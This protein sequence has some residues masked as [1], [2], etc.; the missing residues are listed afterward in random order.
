MPWQLIYTS[1]P[2]T[3][4]AGQTG[5]G[6]VARSKDLRDALIQRLE[7][8]S[9]FQHGDSHAATPPI[10]HAYRIVD[11]RGAKYHVLT[12]LVDAGLDFTNRTNHLAHHLVFTAEELAALPS[13]SLIFQHWTGWR[14]SWTEEPRALEAGDGPAFDE[15]PCGASLPA[16]EWAKLT[17]DAGR[18]AALVTR[19]AANGCWLAS[20]PGGEMTWLALFAESLQ[21]LDPEK[22]LPAQRWQFP[23]TTRLQEQDQPNDFRWR[24][25]EPGSPAAQRA[26]AQIFSP[27]DLPVPSG[28]LAEL[29]RRGPK[30][31]YSVPS[32]PRV[33]TV[34]TIH[35]KPPVKADVSTARPLRLR[36]RDANAPGQTARFD[37]DSPDEPRRSSS[38]RRVVPIAAAILL[39]ALLVTGFWRPGWMMKRVTKASGPPE[40]KTVETVGTEG[41]IISDDFS[42]VPPMQG[43][44]LIPPHSAPLPPSSATLDQLSQI[45]DGIPTYL[46]DANPSEGASLPRIAELESLLTS[47][48]KQS[49]P[50]ATDAIKVFASSDRLVFSG[51][52]EAQLSVTRSEFPRKILMGGEAGLKFELDATEWFR[53]P[54]G[55]PSA[56]FNGK[57]L[58]AASTVFRPADGTTFPPVRIL[59]L[60]EVAPIDLGKSLLQINQ[61]SFD[62]SLVPQLRSKLALIRPPA[63]YDWQLRPFVGK[64]E[65]DLYLQLTDDVPERG[66]E[67]DFASVRAQLRSKIENHRGKADELAKKI[68]ELRAEIEKDQADDI[69]LGER[70]RHK[71]DDPLASFRA[72]VQNPKR[73]PDR[74][75]FQNYLHKV[76]KGKLS[77]GELKKIDQAKLQSPPDIFQSLRDQ[78]AKAGFEKELDGVPNNYFVMRWESLGKANELKKRQDAKKAKDGEVAGLEAKLNKVPETLAATPRVSL[79]IVNSNSNRRFELIRFID[80]AKESKP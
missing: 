8:L 21:L 56:K 27:A 68:N 53:D 42:G 73:E 37:D 66:R 34:P 41:N 43:K 32:V 11:V 14:N 60:A 26:G 46:I 65:A 51:K 62:E 48:F 74:L 5:Y 33:G 3:L 75:A 57:F 76:L 25:C 71:P 12:R 16:Q 39:L 7:Q 10:V 45:L 22:K 54:N 49:P 55:L 23:F 40:K 13:P 79:F 59:M 61:L 28:E 19:P 20:E 29:A 52:D 78:L 72:F 9:Y 58:R 2:R 67:L 36:D 80:P 17:G 31:S 47:A 77:E 35:G 50:L 64:P 63:G 44:P 30:K 18:A 4:T 15:I 1:A 38:A 24:G 69:K 70:L 6:T